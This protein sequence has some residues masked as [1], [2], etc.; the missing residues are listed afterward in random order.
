MLRSS[1][2]VLEEHQYYFGADVCDCTQDWSALDG[3]G[4]PGNV[5]YVGKHI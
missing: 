5:V 2:L 4:G 3:R 1:N